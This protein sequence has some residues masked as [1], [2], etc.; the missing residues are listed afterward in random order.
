MSGDSDR[1]GGDNRGTEAGTGEDPQQEDNG[2]TRRRLLVGSVGVMS[3]AM[4]VGIGVP[5]VLY[6]TGPLR[7]QG[8][9]EEWIRLGSASSVET[10]TQTLM[11]ATV[12]R[13]SGY[14]T[15]SQEISVFVSTENGTDFVA[16]SNVCTHLG[17]R[18]RWVED[19]HEFF[20][21]C[22]NGV[23]AADGTVQSGPPPRPLDRFETKV[24]D[25]QI[26]IKEV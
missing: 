26:F 8:A 12:E 18:V 19:R 9:V 13:R 17:C 20:C 23:F 11:K 21:P 16:F 10:G 3:G 22:H 1:P 24:E 14:L 4:A 7:E 15:E 6:A 2:V 5:A 25:G